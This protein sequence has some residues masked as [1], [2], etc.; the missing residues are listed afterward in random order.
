MKFK[1]LFLSLLATAVLFSPDD[2]S[3]NIKSAIQTMYPNARITE[4]DNEHGVLEVDIWHENK[5]KEVR[6]N[7]L[8]EWIETEYDVLQQEVPATVLEALEIGRASCRE[9]V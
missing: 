7:A 2:L 3:A 5:Q 4:A 9:R 8:E 1:T 6:F